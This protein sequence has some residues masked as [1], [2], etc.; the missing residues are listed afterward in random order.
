MALV[1]RE[2]GAIEIKAMEEGSVR[3]KVRRVE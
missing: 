1:E 2:N 3:K